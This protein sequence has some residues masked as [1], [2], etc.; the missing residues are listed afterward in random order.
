[1]LLYNITIA[2]DAQIEQEWKEWMKTSHI[3]QVMGTG[4]FMDFKFYKMLTHDDPASV[5][6]CVQY[7]VETIE[8]FNQYLQQHAPGL[9]EQQRQRYP[10][11]HAAFQTLLEQV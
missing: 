3:P 8:N 11:R 1:M 6:Y 5:S 10:D 2:V 4:L 7:F 9:M